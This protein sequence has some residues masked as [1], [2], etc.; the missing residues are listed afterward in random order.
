[1][2]QIKISARCLSDDLPRLPRDI[3]EGFFEKI[4][5]LAQASF[6]GKPLH[7]ELKMLRSLP[8]GRYRIIYYYLRNDDVVWIIA[9]GI[10]KEGSKEDI[11]ERV[12]KLFDSG[13]LMPG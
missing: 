6:H 13:D 12:T 3:Q 9:T 10:R 1:M 8:L 11:Y 5:I 4:Q 2:S 7:D